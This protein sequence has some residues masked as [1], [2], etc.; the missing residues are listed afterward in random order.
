MREL[1]AQLSEADHRK[2]KLLATL[3]HE[4]R[5]PLAPI[6]NGLQLMKLAGD[7]HEAISQG[8]LELLKAPIALTAVVN[9]AIESSSAMIGQKR[10]QLTVQFPEQPLPLKILVV[11]DNRDGADS[12][13][14]M[15][16]LMGNDTRTGYDGEQT[17]AM[18]GAY[19]PDVILL[20]IGLPK[21]NGYEACRLIREQA[22]SQAMVLIAVTGWGQEKDRLRTREAG[23][24]HH[25]VKPLE[26]QEL[27]KILE[28]LHAAYEDVRGKNQKA[29]GESS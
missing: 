24:D 22:W 7:Q 29:Q 27:L 23:F 15:L 16:Q 6:R 3:A 17:V 5:D 2:N 21:L 25:L 26:P 20:D 10:H 14:D 13:S 9:S 8:K 4:L 19:R 28:K 12:L 1:A 18:A 11:D